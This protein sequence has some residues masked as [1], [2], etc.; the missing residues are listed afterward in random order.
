MKGWT[1]GELLPVVT[2]LSAGWGAVD[3]RDILWKL[4]EIKGTWLSDRREKGSVSF[5]ISY[6]PSFSLFPKAWTISHQ[7]QTWFLFFRRCLR[8]I[9]A[10]RWINSSVGQLLSPLIITAT[11]GIVVIAKLL[12]LLNYQRQR[13]GFPLAKLLNE[14]MIRLVVIDNNS[15]SLIRSILYYISIYL[16]YHC[17]FVE[18]RKHDE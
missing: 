13:V 8:C 4:C 5:V 15:L 7:W 18:I 17:W 9:L 10:F 1:N 12:S 2:R 6:S 14:N 11:V 16:Y 3:S